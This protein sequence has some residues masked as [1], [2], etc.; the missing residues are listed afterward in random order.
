MIETESTSYT[1]I[2]ELVEREDRKNDG[3]TKYSI[4]TAKSH[5]D[6]EETALHTVTKHAMEVE[7]TGGH[8]AAGDMT[9]VTVIASLLFIIL[10]NI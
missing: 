2:P 5:E 9:I 3:L 8:R 4:N 1:G 7:G 6:T 10:L